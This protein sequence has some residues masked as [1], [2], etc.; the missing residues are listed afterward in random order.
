[1]TMFPQA[2]GP[3]PEE[4]ARIAR[5]A[6]PKGTLAMWLRDGLGAIYTDAD[7]GDLYP[8]RGQPALAPWRLAVV[9][10]LQYAE[11]LTDR[12]AAEA[13][14]VRLDWKYL[15]GLA[16]SDPGF[17]ASVLTEF[18]Q[19]LLAQGAEQRLLD[20]LLV[21]CRERGWLKAGG[22][23]R[24]DSTHV[25][26]AV[27]S[28]HHL[29]TVGETL[30]AVLEDLAEVAA[31]WL[32]SWLP[33]EWFKRYE[34]RMDSRRL[35]KHEPERRRLA[36]QIGQDGMQLLRALQDAHTPVAARELES[37][38]VLRQVWPQFYE[39]REGQVYWRDGPAQGAQETIVSPY[40]PDAR[41]AQKREEA[42]CG[43]KVHLTETCEPDLPEL[44]VQVKTRLSPRPDVKDTLEVQQE[45]EQRQL[46]P[47]EHLLDGGYL[48]S[49]VLVKHP[50]GL[51]IVGPVPR[52]T[53]WQ[54]LAGQGFDLTHFHIDWSTQRVLCP[55]GQPSRSWRERPEREGQIQVA[56]AK[57]VCQACPVRCACTKGDHRELQLQPRAQLEALQRQRAVQQTPEFRQAYALRSGVEATI[58]Q[59]VRRL[60]L[61]QSRYRGL[62]KVQLQELVTAT[63]LNCLRLYAYV[64]GVPRGITW[65]S[66]LAR[67]QRRREQLQPAA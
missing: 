28:L 6:N 10:L 42:W 46:L 20:K 47:E 53:S 27:R 61:R 19:R 34:G 2:I 32:L 36:E 44:V 64:N 54:A 15:L 37:V 35:P 33:E 1:M 67:L 52:D 60:P 5:A 65:V 29:E 24:T 11:D 14:R 17:D 25:L 4:T 9:T 12:Q 40:D 31:D 39:E 23:M 22:K 16:L 13:V 66:H 51:R 26:A 7:F 3:I 49:E 48:E 50:A 58:S 21:V 8:E 63:A 45:L 57:A 43:Y 59:A 41:L 56:F 18:R 30:R 62:P 55:Q 38:Q